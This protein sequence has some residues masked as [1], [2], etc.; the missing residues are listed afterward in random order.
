MGKSKADFKA[1][2][3]ALGLTQQNF[4]DEVGV[5]VLAVKRWEHPDWMEP[6]A[7]AWELIEACEAAQRDVVDAAVS[8]AVASG[9][10]PVQ[11]TYYRTQEQYDEFG[12]DPGPF[13]MANANARLVAHR[14]RSLGCEVDFAYPDEDGNV[15]HGGR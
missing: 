8:A 1:R 5:R 7:D 2:R 11:V 13:G 4:A 9:M 14:L 10:G 15:Y 12:R 3:E 6:P